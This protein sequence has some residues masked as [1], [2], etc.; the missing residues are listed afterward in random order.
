[1][2]TAYKEAYEA[3]TN[4][5]PFFAAKKIFRGRTFV[6]TIRVGTK[7]LFNGIIFLLYA[8]LLCRGISNLERYLKTYPTDKIYLMHIIYLQ[9]VIMK[10]LKMKKEI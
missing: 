5:D 2:I 3:L 9:Y 4:N 7:I 1:M 6:S 10:L 8:K